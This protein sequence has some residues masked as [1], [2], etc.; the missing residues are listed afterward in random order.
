MHGISTA[1]ADDVRVT[2][3]AKPFFRRLFSRTSA[4]AAYFFMALVVYVGWIGRADRS[5]SA[6]EGLGYALGIIG[7]SLML[8]LL[9]YSV[10]K[11]L[12]LLRRL[13]STRYW[14][15]AHMMLGIV[16]PV[17]ILYHSNFKVGSL[18]SKVALY[19]TLLV[20]ASGIVG[21]YLYSQIHHGLYGRKATLN[22]LTKQMQRSTSNLSQGDGL[23]DDMRQELQTLAEEVLIPAESFW[24]SIRRPVLMALTTRVNYFRLNRL[25]KRRLSARSVTSTAVEQHQQGLRIATRKFIGR[26]LRQIRWVAQFSAYER[27]FSWWHVIHVPFFLMMVFSALVH[28]LA[29]HMY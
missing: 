5:I 19:C 4:T 2:S 15:R 6:G 18:N 17:I 13:G 22:D 29:V 1:A 23:I 8:M 26:Y 21:R 16:G 20:A 12:P 10:R 24:E 28:V 3:S 14:F 7:G 27:L 11:R 25:V 9:L